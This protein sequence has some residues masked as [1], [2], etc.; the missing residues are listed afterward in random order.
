MLSKALSAKNSLVAVTLAVALP[1]QA[2]ELYNKNETVL[3]AN[4]EA[5]FAAMHSDENYA[6]FGN[7]MPGSSSWREG[8]I[9][10][11]LSG[12]QGLG[13]SG[14]LYGAFSLVS[15]GT[16]GDGDAAGFTEGTERR[17]AVEDKYLGWKS[18]DLFP[19]LGANG[20]DISAG[21]QKIVIGDGFLIYG[22]ALNFGDVDRGEN[23][24]RGG[25]YYI[26][27]RKAFDQTAVLRI[28]GDKGWRGDLMYLASDNHAQADTKLA[29]ATLEHVT[30]PGTLG[31]TYIHG[32]DVNER[33]ATPAQLER[34]GMDTVSI[35]GTGSLGVKNLNLAFEYATEDRS[36]GRENAWYLEGSWTFAD[37]PWTPTATYRFS[38]FSEDFDP[39]FYGLSRGYG[40]WFQG[41]VA[42][43]YAGP[44]NSNAKVHHVGLKAKPR[45]DLTVGALFFDFNPI[46]KDTSNLGGRELDV[47]IEWML[48][49]HFMISPLIG[50]Y[51]PDKSAN[52]GGL[53][54]GSNDTNTY[55]Q[56]IVGTFF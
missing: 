3:N 24:D 28:G 6:V 56:L 48:N 40:T 45:E 5:V 30:E 32:L 20:I 14:S 25:A 17:T 46:N 36:S 29:I 19:T 42:S 15:S 35:R 2:Y 18:G 53:Q 49:E 21:S 13:S 55:V 31:L 52:Q 16:W 23:F 51:K 33:F 50:L 7:R 37:M 9:K 8:Y 54:L 47:Y 43:N 4:L 1:A 39:L 22:D 27:A 12:T 10:Y 34:D 38:R 11:G 26:A 44:F 41:E